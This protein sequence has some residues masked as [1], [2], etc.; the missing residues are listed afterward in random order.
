VAL[1]CQQ[2]VRF[3]S[4]DASSTLKFNVIS[5]AFVIILWSDNGLQI[6][7]FFT[8]TVISRAGAWIAD[9]SLR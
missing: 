1:L 9:M 7:A 2:L 3:F 5:R 8:L 6:L 4:K